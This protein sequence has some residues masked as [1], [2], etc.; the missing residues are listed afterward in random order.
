MSRRVVKI[1]T[2]EVVTFVYTNDYTS[3]LFV[4]IS[5]LQIGYEYHF[6]S[7]LNFAQNCFLIATINRN[8]WYIH[9][10]ISTVQIAPPLMQY[11]GVSLGC[12]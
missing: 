8:F 4:S 5:G 6:V 7:L 3:V 10:I 1:D 9:Q 2:S 12:V 11:S